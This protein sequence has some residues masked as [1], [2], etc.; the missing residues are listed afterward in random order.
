MIIGYHSSLPYG[1]RKAPAIVE[2]V[3]RQR[4]LSD[5][6]RDGVQIIWPTVVTRVYMHI[7][8]KATEYT[9]ARTT[10]YYELTCR[11]Y[12]PPGATITSMQYHGEY[13]WI[14]RDEA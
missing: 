12:V 5:A 14:G 2:K 10:P 7:L 13:L 11:A 6:R 1:S 4:L 3:V 9:T 8:A